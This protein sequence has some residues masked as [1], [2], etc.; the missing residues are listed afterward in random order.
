M[1]IKKKIE[2]QGH[3]FYAEF[4]DNAS[5]DVGCVYC[6]KCNLKMYISANK[7]NKYEITNL[8]ISYINLSYTCDEFILMSI[9]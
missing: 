9:L 4:D 8:T 7:L 2:I 6:V 5:K 1:I 3:I